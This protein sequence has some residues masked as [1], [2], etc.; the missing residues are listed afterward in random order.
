MTKKQKT[1]LGIFTPLGILALVGGGLGIGYAIWHHNHQSDENQQYDDYYTIDKNTQHTT[2]SNIY[3]DGQANPESAYQ[4]IECIRLDTVLTNKQIKG[5]KI[6]GEINYPL[7][8]ANGLAI[9][10]VGINNARIAIGS[11][12]H[13]GIIFGNTEANSS[14]QI[15]KSTFIK[16]IS[17]DGQ[18]NRSD[19]GISF[20]TDISKDTSITIS[21]CNINEVYS[22]LIFRNNIL[23]EVNISN[24]SIFAH[25]YGIF[26]DDPIRGTL[27]INNN[28]IV[29]HLFDVNVPAG[30]GA[31]AIHISSSYN[32]D[33]VVQITNNLLDTFAGSK[34]SP[35][36]LYAHIIAITTGS[37][38]FTLRVNSNSCYSQLISSNS[39]TNLGYGFLFYGTLKEITGTNNVLYTN[40][41]SNPGPDSNNNSFKSWYTTTNN[42]TW[43]DIRI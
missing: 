39:S 32:V 19:V 41:D 11:N 21:N 5:V 24:N 10:I 3:R 13:A 27:T 7:F 42:W 37:S 8:V 4:N 36:N 34:N 22:G 12:S 14:Y 33:G 15:S 25:R 6:D 16:D 18:P 35:L 38:S 29:A 28:N 43:H 20:L 31:E 1:L 17:V 2:V 23:G 40:S 30:S 26:C 9:D